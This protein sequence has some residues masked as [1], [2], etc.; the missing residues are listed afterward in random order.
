MLT[1]LSVKGFKTLLDFEAPLSQVSV[2]VGPNN[3]GKSN[4]L[5]AL[6]F[7]TNTFKNGPMNA[8]SQAGGPEAVLAKNGKQQLTFELKAIF[9]GIPITYYLEPRIG[10]SAG[11]EWFNVG[12]N[13]ETTGGWRESQPQTGFFIAKNTEFAVGGS[14]GDVLRLTA[15]HPQCPAVLR[16]FYNFLCGGFTADFSSAALRSSSQ[17]DPNATL[18]ATGEGLAAVLDNLDG[19][20]P[21]V[22]SQIDKEVH[23]AIPRVTRVVTIPDVNRGFKVL[24]VAEGDDVFRAQSVSDG[25]LLYI[26][27]STVAQMSGGET[28]VGL[29]EPD[30]GIHPRRIREV[31]D[32]VYRLANAGSQFVITTHSPVLLNEFRDH[33]ESVLILDR[34]EAGTHARQL[35][36]LPDVEQQLRDVQL[37]DLW[38]SGVLGG[39]PPVP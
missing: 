25:V 19:S 31:L 9:D 3:C 5:K 2:L 10:L 23:A 1:H 32:Q 15:T 34:D 22:R 35:S 28:L 7:I 11:R 38:Y 29:E 16:R 6:T 36:S 24:G 20:R 37:G 33:P 39:V 27:L 12:P 18:S 21:T 8:I 13:A 30:K 17:V 4:V 26:A 14:P